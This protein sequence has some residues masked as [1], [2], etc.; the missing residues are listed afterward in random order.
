MTIDEIIASHPD[1]AQG[2]AAAAAAINDQFGWSD[3]AYTATQ[4]ADALVQAV[5]D[6]PV[7][8]AILDALLTALAAAAQS[9]PSIALILANVQAGAAVRLASPSVRPVLMASL[10]A[11]QIAPLL[12]L[13]RTAPMETA[14]TVAARRAELARETAR[15]T[16]ENR[17]ASFTG[18]V[19]AAFDA[20][21]ET[22]TD[23]TIRTLWT[24]APQ[25]AGEGD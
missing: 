24:A 16:L 4:L 15:S 25:P 21:G 2:N 6:Q 7:A 12:P 10:S 3:R 22:P 23:E 11:E 17:L 5:G 18:R 1:T 9:S 19:L 13:L 20:A 8:Q 14:Q